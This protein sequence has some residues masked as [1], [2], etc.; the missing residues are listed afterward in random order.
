MKLLITG[1]LGFIGSNFILKLLEKFPDYQITNLDDELYGSNHQNVLQVKNLNNYEFVKGNITDNSIVEKLVSKVDIVI[2]FAAESHVDRSISN[3]KP[4]IDSNI[5]GVFTILENIKKY[6]KKLVHISTDEVFGSLESESASEDYKLNPSSPYASSK[7]SA[8]LLINSYFKTYDCEVI[9]TRCT[10][11]YGPRQFPEKLIPK[12][13]IRAELDKSI[14]VYGT[15]KNIRDWIFVDD[16]CSAIEMIIHKGTEG[17]SYNISASNEIDN[18][19]IIE[20]ILS[21]LGKPLDL[22]NF[23]DDRPGHDFR[24]SLDSSKIRSLGWKPK[25]SFEE[26][27]KKTIEWYQKN[28]LWWNDIDRNI[29]TE[30][31]WK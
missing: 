2:N 30:T 18:I 9:I 3:A 21:F 8:E 19:T 10:N 14:P 20:K 24:Y 26:G 17:E 6:K 4:F 27:I 5:L 15:G 28:K 16:H 25:T 29:L 1:G 7:A 12:T 31:P 11:N 22:I 23:V 13:I